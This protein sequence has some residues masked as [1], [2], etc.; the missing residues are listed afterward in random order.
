MGPLKIGE[1]LE[2]SKA[3]LDRLISTPD[4]KPLKEIIFV[5]YSLIGSINDGLFL[6][7]NQQVGFMG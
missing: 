6:S 2:T 4:R 5:T 7:T 3:I 1:D